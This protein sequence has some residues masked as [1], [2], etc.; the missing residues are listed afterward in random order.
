MRVISSS[1]TEPFFVEAFVYFWFLIREYL[2]DPL[3]FLQMLNANMKL[4]YEQKIDV[5]LT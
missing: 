4:N 1:W 3:G 5:I 2:R